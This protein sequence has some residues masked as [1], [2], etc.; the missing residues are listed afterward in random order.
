MET[1]VVGSGA[2]GRWFGDHTPDDVAFT[3]ADM[4]VAETAAEQAHA[5]RGR[6][7]RAVPLDTNESFGLV[8][9][10]VPLTDAIQAIER[11]AG[12]AEAAV[13]DLTGQMAAP[14]G[15]MTSIVPNRERVSYHPLFAP[16]R[17]PGRIAV[18][19]G[20]SGPVTD[21][22]EGWLT[23]AGNELITID[24]ATH[25]EAMAT[26]QGRTH[27]AI[28][29]FGLAADNVPSEL[30]TPIFADLM[31]L[32][33]RV[34]NGESRVYGDIQSVFGGAEAIASAASA[35]ADADD[36][37]FADLYRRAGGEGNGGG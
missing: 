1:L 17:S 15:A 21:R 24:P 9:I 4:A 22:V 10:A 7:A 36:D 5:T 31:E 28:L 20:A 2:I 19:T 30:A 13:I 3:D 18:S 29:A 33:D 26:I 11:H 16:N 23:E 12:K 8:C 6:S 27:A 37:A 35:L 14:L 34:T 32:L 25:D